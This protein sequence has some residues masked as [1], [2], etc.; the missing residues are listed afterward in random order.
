MKTHSQDGFTLVELAVVL[1]IVLALA[2]LLAPVV[3][4]A[5]RAAKRT[6]TQALLGKVDA[7]LRRFKQDVGVYPFQAQD[8]LATDFS[9][10]DNRLAYH[11]AHAMGTAERTALKADVAN[12]SGAYDAGA[13]RFT[14]ATPSVVLLQSDVTNRPAIPPALN[15]MGR[16]RARMMIHAGDLAVCG[17]DANKASP[18]LPS[19][20]VSKGW[21]AE[22]LAGDLPARNVRNDAIVD[23]YG[24]PLLYVCPVVCGMQGGWLA[25]TIMPTYPRSVLIQP[26]YFGFQAVGRDPVTVLASDIRLTAAREYCLEFELWSL[27]ADRQGGPDRS[28]SANQDNIP[29]G[30]YL[31]GLK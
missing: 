22:Y 7:G 31:K 6:N 10:I 2:G 28:A 18:L 4:I 20:G 19:G 15:R 11:L 24:T 21:G 9:H 30:P 14:V 16:E 12:A 8:P 5:S 1:S 23:Y 25:P 26:E 27:G 29:A 13:H 3:Q 17:V